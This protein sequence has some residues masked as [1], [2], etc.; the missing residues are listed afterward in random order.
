MPPDQIPPGE[1]LPGKTH[2]IFFLLYLPRT[3]TSLQEPQTFLSISF[4]Y[5]HYCQVL[6]I[7]RLKVVEFSPLRPGIQRHESMRFQDFICFHLR[8]YLQYQHPFHERLLL[9]VLPHCM[10]V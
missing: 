3:K 6:D 7:L 2:A 8:H 10:L 1:F 5:I 9:C 4:V